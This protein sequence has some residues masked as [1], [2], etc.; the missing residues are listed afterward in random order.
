MEETSCSI[1]R[2]VISSTFPEQRKMLLLPFGLQ[3]A[4]MVEASA[5]AADARE[6]D[7]ILS[8]ATAL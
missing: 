2:V 1:S 8:S 7:F 3:V 4:H 6:I 5:A